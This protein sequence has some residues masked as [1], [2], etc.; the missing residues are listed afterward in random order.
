MHEIYFYLPVTALHFKKEKQQQRNAFMSKKKR[1]NF[2]PYT[3]I[4]LE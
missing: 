4:Y 3:K 2:S 1:S